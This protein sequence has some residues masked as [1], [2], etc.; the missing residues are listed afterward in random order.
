MYLLYSRDIPKGLHVDIF[1][2]VPEKTKYIIYAPVCV[3]CT[4]FRHRRCFPLIVALL[5]H[6]VC[7]YIYA[8]LR[9]CVCVS[10]PPREFI[11]NN[12]LDICIR[13]IK[14]LLVRII[15]N[16]PKFLWPATIFMTY[17]AASVNFY[18]RP[19]I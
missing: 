13:E 10:V 17:A 11:N 9:M 15:S 2:P 3:L 4:C 7:E 1:F 14:P 18:D 8:C 16:S 5:Q 6:R 12:A 19:P